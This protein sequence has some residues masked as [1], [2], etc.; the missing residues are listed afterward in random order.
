L[1]VTENLERENP[2]GM[3]EARGLLIIRLERG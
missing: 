1:S 3:I 2:D